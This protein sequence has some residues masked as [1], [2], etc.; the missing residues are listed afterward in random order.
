MIFKPA[1][2]EISKAIIGLDMFADTKDSYK[3]I[4]K[5]L[6]SDLKHIEAVSPVGYMVGLNV[7]LRGPEFF[8]STYPEGWNAEYQRMNY[9]FMDPMVA[10]SIANTGAKRWSDMPTI[11]KASPVFIRAKRFGLVHGATMSV[12]NE[13]TEKRSIA[14]VAN[15]ERDLDDAELDRVIAAL[16]NLSGRAYDGI[17]LTIEETDALRLTSQ[18]LS[19]KQI[20]GEL[21]IAEI[22]VRQRLTRAKDKLGATTPA[23]AVAIAIRS[24]IL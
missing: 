6:A 14:S 22:T 11:A 5:E 10:W 9:M 15:S 17:K 24:Q 19:Q 13:E 8:C 4:P 23:Q 3:E 18:G 12:Y 20:A 7:S 16:E 1:Q 21:G 2:G